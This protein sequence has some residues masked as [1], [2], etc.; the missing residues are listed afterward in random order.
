MKDDMQTKP[1]TFDE[2]AV[3][4][5]RNNFQG[6]SQ[7]V[8]RGRTIRML[9]WLVLW[10]HCAYARDLPQPLPVYIED[11]HA[12]TF[13][14]LATTLELEKSHVLVM[15]DA[16][17]DSAV[18]LKSKVTQDG[19]RKVTSPKEQYERITAW[20]RDGTIQASDWLT[21]LMPKPIERV[22]WIRSPNLPGDSDQK[23]KDTLLL[24]TRLLGPVL[25]LR[26]EPVSLEQCRSNLPPDLPVVVSIDLDFFAGLDPIAAEKRFTEVWQTVSQYPRL[27]AVSFA[28][29]RPWLTS[30][31]EADRLVRLALQAA[32]SMPG[33]QVHFEPFGIE[34][35]DL[36][37]RAIDYSRKK[38]SVPRFN[39]AAASPELKSL[40]INHAD[41][42]VV[43][44]E[45]QSWQGLLGR[46]RAKQ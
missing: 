11:N 38:E 21:P 24:Q 25:G 7:S 5:A 42:M 1:F 18:N 31:A 41:R 33:A 13:Q 2:P 15:I 16:H 20:R 43:T 45:S 29:S 30:D 35:R 10:S 28:I 36:T 4:P 46:W 22:L 37:R 19:I 34:G 23:L 39:L 6:L 8:I 44:F 26:F 32:L 12:G 40:L 27:T 3:N 17:P 9:L 14:F